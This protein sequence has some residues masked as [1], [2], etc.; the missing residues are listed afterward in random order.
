MGQKK[1]VSVINMVSAGTIEHRMTE[2]LKFKSSLAEG[3]LDQ[4]EDVIFLEESK[5]IENVAC[6]FVS[7]SVWIDAEVF[8]GIEF[9][10]AWIIGGMRHRLYALL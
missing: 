9:R 6:R 2:I 7:A 3:I 1:K 10:Q 5:H 4:G 8:Q